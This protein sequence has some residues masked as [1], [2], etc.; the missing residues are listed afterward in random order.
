MSMKEKSINKNAILNII[1]TLTNIVFP[2]ITFPYISRILNP[3]GIGA[4]S[5]FHLL[6]LM[7]F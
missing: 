7:V 6:V 1:L 4:I 2:L 5:F 3:S